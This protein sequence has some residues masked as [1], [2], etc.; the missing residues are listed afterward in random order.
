MD[1]TEEDSSPLQ[2]PVEYLYQG[3]QDILSELNGK[4]LELA[5]LVLTLWEICHGRDQ[6]ISMPLINQWV[7]ILQHN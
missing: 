3:W 2:N 6:N 5:V 4:I 1:L 7:E